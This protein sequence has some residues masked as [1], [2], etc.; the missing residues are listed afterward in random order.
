MELILKDYIIGTIGMDL[1]NN[2]LQMGIALKVYG[3]VTFVE[4][5]Q[6]IMQMEMYIQVDRKI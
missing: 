4:V 5:E 3:E 2:S 1:E 6:F